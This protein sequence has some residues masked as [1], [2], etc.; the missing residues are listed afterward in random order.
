MG[1]PWSDD[2]IGAYLRKRRAEGA[3]VRRQRRL[4]K[5]R[6]RA[7]KEKGGK[8]GVKGPARPG[9][10]VPAPGDPEG[11]LQGPGDVVMQVRGATDTRARARAR[12]H[13]QTHVHVDT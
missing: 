6:L 9:E 1:F 13:A 12:T 2:L 10:G 4:E 3:D 7:E 5:Q 11:P 8:A